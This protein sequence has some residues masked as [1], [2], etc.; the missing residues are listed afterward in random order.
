MSG[1]PRRVAGRTAAR[2]LLAGGLLPAALLCGCGIAPEPAAR[3]VAQD[4]PG[5]QVPPPSS[6]GGTIGQGR[7]RLFLVR[8]DALVAVSRT[9]ARRKD[10]SAA[11]ADLLTG[12]STEERARGLTSALPADAGAV[13]LRLEQGTALVS[14]GDQ[15]S[16]SGRSDQVLALAQVVSTLDALPEVMAVRFLKD[17]EPLDVPRGDGSLS[18]GPLTAAD[19]A[20]LRAP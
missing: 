17:G 2:A 8:G 1:L 7:E 4:A 14:L 6:G 11:L 9:T 12:P 15:L 10:P 13:L 19:Y 18:T 3:A 5:P 20:A 16:D